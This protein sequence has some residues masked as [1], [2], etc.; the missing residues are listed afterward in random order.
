MELNLRVPFGIN[1]CGDLGVRIREGGINTIVMF[2]VNGL[3]KSATSHEPW[4]TGLGR[5]SPGLGRVST[6]KVLPWRTC[7]KSAF[8]ERNLGTSRGVYLVSLSLN[9]YYVIYLERFTRIRYMI[10]MTTRM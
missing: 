3:Q 6:Q 2:A 10:T 1:V 8:S 4:I 9:L 7:A 5:V